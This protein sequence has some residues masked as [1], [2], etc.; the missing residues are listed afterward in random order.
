MTLAAFLTGALL[1]ILIP[2]ALLVAIGCYWLFVARK[3][4]EF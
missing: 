2:V 1:T 3:R 4:D